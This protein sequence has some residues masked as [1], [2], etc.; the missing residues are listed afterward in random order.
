M[1]FNSIEFVVFFPT[2]CL[3]Y[4]LLPH[5]FRWAL[6]LLAS[7]CF[8][9]AWRPEYLLLILASTVVDYVAAQRMARCEMQ[10]GRLKYLALSLLCNL[11]L[12]FSFKY[13][14]FMSQSVEVVMA[15]CGLPYSPPRLDVLLPVGISFYTF[16]TLGYTLDVYRGQQKPE[17]HLGYFALYVAFFPQLVAGPIERARNLLPQFRARQTF[18]YD[19]VVGGLRLILWGLFKKIVIADRLAELVQPVY[20][21]PESY[22]GPVLAL[23]TAAFAYQI[24]CDFSG[25][26][27][28][29][30][31]AARV[32][33]IRLM[34]NFNRPYLAKN[35]GEFWSR[36]H[37]SLSTWFRDY[38]YIPLGG[39]RVALPHWTFN[40]LVTFTVSGL[41][42]GA[43]WTF[44][45][46]GAL[47]GTYYILSR[48]TRSVRERCTRSMGLTRLP[49]LHGLLQTTCT[50]ALVCLG[51]IFFRAES[52]SDALVI[53]TGLTEGWNV[54]SAVDLLRDALK[55]VSLREL[56]LVFSLVVLLNV[57]ERAQ[58]D[59]DFASFLARRNT[60]VRWCTYLALILAI[61]NLG[62]THEVPFI[63]F[64]F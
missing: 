52:V 19:D 44:I 13:F 1:L 14:N 43:S 28:V 48:A 45:I 53:L 40:I 47:H 16:Q 33:G 4:F 30:I 61:F 38:V 46:W 23:A 8:Y 10:R 56:L 20:A 12:L 59:S 18:V 27:D 42:H 22:P 64:Q 26:S 2:V 3:L 39:N 7:Y 17:R 51:W 41:W 49:L 34:M 32:F 25:Y 21:S 11:G 5:R 60:V 36:W 58:S 29:A 24:Y 62:I 54:V 35:I 50:F 6:L 37:I 55:P 9:M 15:W 31:G 57:V 63:Y